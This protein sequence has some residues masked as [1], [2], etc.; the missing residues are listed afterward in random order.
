MLNESVLGLDSAKREAIKKRRNTIGPMNMLVSCN[1]ILDVSQ[2]IETLEA[3]IQD[4]QNEIEKR[5]KKESIESLLFGALHQK[6]WNVLRGK[7]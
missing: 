2:H 7:R 6:L 1:L 4:H 5:V 3:A